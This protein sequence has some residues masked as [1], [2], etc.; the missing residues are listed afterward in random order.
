MEPIYLDHNATTPV[1]PA[2]IES[3]LPYL[4]GRF[5]NASSVHQF[6]RDAKVALENAREQIAAFINCEPAE[7]YFTSGGTESDN[8][9]VLGTAYYLRSK[10][11]HLIIGATEHHA[12]LEPAEYLH[13]KEGFALELLPVDGEGFASSD[14]LRELVTDKTAIV[15]VM[16]ANNE[17]G[18]IQDVASL[19]EAAL[20][21]G[22]LFH[23]DA[24]QSTGK[25]EVDVK[26]LGVDMLSLTGHKIYGPKG[27][28]ALFIRQG[29]KLAPLLY[30]GSHEKKRRPGTENVAGAVGLAKA[31]EIAGQ[32]RRQ[33]FDRWS[34]LA[35]YFVEAVSARIPD[36]HFNGSRSARLP[37]TVNL[38]FQGIEGESIV[39]ALDLEQVAV[40]SGSA[41]TSGA[42][43]PSHVLTAM[44][45]PAIVAQGS[46]RFS[47]G[48]ST[49]QGQL[50][51]VLEKLP[52]IVERLRSLS[53]V[54]QRSRA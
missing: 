13:K 41:C 48:R 50:D 16:H 21:R 32:R 7:L 31:L 35:N 9:A 47:M 36:V 19:S 49:T 18:T 14:R 34:S 40:S 33:D 51:Y 8:M 39:L 28:G 5:G 24:V 53:P 10:R 23:T 54:Y 1:D 38:S 46:I 2:V 30:G 27:T 4:G 25:I 44:G 42:T 3:M 45:I 43:E 20:H 22:A 26:Q 15:S 11:N 37:Q 52:P 6:G 29:V 12:V 17:T